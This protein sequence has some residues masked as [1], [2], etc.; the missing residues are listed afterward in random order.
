MFRFTKNMKF[1]PQGQILCIFR[2]FPGHVHC[3]RRPSSVEL[4]GD[5]NSYQVQVTLLYYECLPKICM[6]TTYIYNRVRINRARLPILL[7]V[8]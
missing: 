4:A 6:A 3:M 1:L 7:V 8:S 2:V 5:D